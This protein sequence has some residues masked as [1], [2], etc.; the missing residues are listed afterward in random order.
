MGVS[1]ISRIL[2][3]QV[4]SPANTN[5][6]Q[7]LV[8]NPISS[9]YSNLQARLSSIGTGELASKN[10]DWCNAHELLHATKY[11]DICIA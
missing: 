11:N 10:D 8:S 2:T 6:P 1:L 3:G 4:G 9:N 7:R 5:A